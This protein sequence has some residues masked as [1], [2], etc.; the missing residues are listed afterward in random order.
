MTSR[1]PHARWSAPAFVIVLASIALLITTIA[2]F[3]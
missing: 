1:Q 2:A 3:T